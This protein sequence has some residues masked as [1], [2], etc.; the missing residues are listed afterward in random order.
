MIIRGDLFYQ[1]AS[2]GG[3]EVQSLEPA[4]PKACTYDQKPI[5]LNEQMAM[6]VSI[7]DKTI[8]LQCTSSWWHQIDY[9]C[10]KPYVVF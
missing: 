5:T 6:K 1:I 10:Q 4:E 7:G 8:F 3:L 9:Y 2:E